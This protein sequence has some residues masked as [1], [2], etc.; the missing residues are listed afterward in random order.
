[1]I[2]DR[3]LWLD[4]TRTQLCEEGAPEADFLLAPRGD[5]LSDDQVQQYHLV[6]DAD[7]RVHQEGH[8]PPAPEPGPDL[9]PADE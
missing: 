3:H 2:A 9:P 6:L 1:M 7:G 5:Y 4:V 8:T